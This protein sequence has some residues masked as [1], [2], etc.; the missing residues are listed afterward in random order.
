MVLEHT[1]ISNFE[2]WCLSLDFVKTVNV[3][4][5]ISDST[6]TFKDNNMKLKT[7]GI[8]LGYLY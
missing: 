5:Q 7:G 3:L 8:R 4:Y 6:Q 1:T 2:N